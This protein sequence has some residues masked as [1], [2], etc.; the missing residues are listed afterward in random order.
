[1]IYL[2]NYLPVRLYYS[3]ELDAFRLEAPLADRDT[4]E[5]N[6]DFLKNTLPSSYR[7]ITTLYFLN[8]RIFPPVPLGTSMFTVY[9]NYNHPY[10]TVYIEWIAFP[11]M[12]NVN[13]G[14]GNFCFFAYTTNPCPEAFP[15]YIRNEDVRTMITIDDKELADYFIQTPYYNR[16]LDRDNYVLYSINS[17]LLYWKG[18]T[19]CICVP[20]NDPSDFSTLVE[21]QKTMYPKIR[22]HSS[23][24]GNSGV[25]LAEIKSKIYRQ[26]Q[27]D[28]WWTV[29]VILTVVLFLVAVFSYRQYKIYQ[30]S[31]PPPIPSSKPNQSKNVKL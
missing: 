13:I 8:P 1:M 14:T 10:E 22:N 27:S 20:S 24:T 30:A 28:Q 21:C 9:Q 17:A 3:E 23:Y 7:L 16:I 5:Y 12:S 11:I 2:N 18:T 6:E 31:K 15:V 26:K 19:E 29:Y 25:P 4:L